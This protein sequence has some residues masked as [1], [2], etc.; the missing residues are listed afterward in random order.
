MWIHRSFI[1]VGDYRMIIYL[2]IWVRKSSEWT[3][4]LP[5]Q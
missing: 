1:Y 3:T 4:S 5:M 2:V